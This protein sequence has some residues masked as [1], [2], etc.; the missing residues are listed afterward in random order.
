[1]DDNELYIDTK[2][3]EVFA[4]LSQYQQLAPTITQLTASANMISYYDKR[5]VLLYHLSRHP[6]APEDLKS[7]VQAHKMM[8]IGDK[9]FV[10]AWRTFLT[11][12]NCTTYWL[13][14]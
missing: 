2:F 12:K 11:Q 4:A 10:D 6:E 3:K 9:A 1:M 14:L 7:A 13:L 5:I 8:S